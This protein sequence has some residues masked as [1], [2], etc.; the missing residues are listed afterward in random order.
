M[1]RSKWEKSTRVKDAEK[2]KAQIEAIFERHD[3]QQDVVYDLYRLA[4]PDFD[5]INKVH[6]HPEAGYALCEFICRRFMEFDRKHHPN[7]FAGGA[8]LNW[9]F[10]PKSNLDPWG[11]DISSCSFE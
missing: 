10:T 7:V 1:L 4:I 8:W 6:G 2:L 3:H 9:G 11:I 5:S